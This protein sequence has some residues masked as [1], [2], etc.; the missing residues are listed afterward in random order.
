MKKKILLVDDSNAIRM[1]ERM[2][3]GEK[4]FELIEAVDGEEALFAAARDRPDL[5]L[6]DVNMPKIDG[7]E[8]LRRMRRIDILRSIPVIVITM[9]KE[10]EAKAAIAGD[11]YTDFVTKPL[12]AGTLNEKVQKFLRP[13]VP[14]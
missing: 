14:V 4:D 9:M 3:L 7:F 6:L 8:T 11:P 10:E 2:I 5:I 12:Y 13:P 1:F